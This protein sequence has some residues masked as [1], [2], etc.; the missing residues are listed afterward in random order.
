MVRPIIRSCICNWVGAIMTTTR[1]Q[2]LATIDERLA[3]AKRNRHSPEEVPSKLEALLDD[4]EMYSFDDDAERDLMLW[5][6]EHVKTT[7]S[8]L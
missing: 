7:P 5:L 8:P 1:E 3:T 6:S 4:A 2:L